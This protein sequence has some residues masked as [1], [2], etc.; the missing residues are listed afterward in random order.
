M[1]QV[2]ISYKHDDGDFALILK[3]RLERAGFAGWI[4]DNLQAGEDW[5]EMIDRAIRESMALVVILSPESVASEYVTYEWAFALGA[6][7]PVV[8]VLLRPTALHPRLNELQFLDF[9]NRR[10]RPWDALIERLESLSGERGSRKRPGRPSKREVELDALREQLA[11][12]HWDLR[13]E[14]VRALGDRRDRA[15]VPV[16]ARMLATDRSVRVRAAAAEALGWIGD[17]AAA[18]DLLAALDAD[19]VAVQAAA[20]EALRR[21]GRGGEEQPRAAKSS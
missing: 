12:K 15:A 21:M 3:D 20:R 17:E 19:H 11:D 10:A 16:L 13:V 1:A 9:T 7:V 18:P 5:R 8:P 6:G 2:F 14:A 4:D